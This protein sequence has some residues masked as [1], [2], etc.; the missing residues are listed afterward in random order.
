MSTLTGCGDSIVYDDWGESAG[1]ARVEGVILS[2]PGTPVGRAL[3]EV[4][5]CGPAFDQGF[6]ANA[7]AATD[8]KYSLRL[9]LPPVGTY[10]GSMKVECD[11]T[12]NRGQATVRKEITFAPSKP[13]VT[14]LVVNF[15]LQP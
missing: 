6:G 5:R 2:G 8:G 13:Q 3:I 11:I 10:R 15:T 7:R 9:E 12:V 1:Y 14:P 4:G